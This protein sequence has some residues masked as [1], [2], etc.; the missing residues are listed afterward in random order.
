VL[1]GHTLALV[2]E[3]LAR[4]GHSRLLERLRTEP[5]FR[6]TT[7]IMREINVGR[8][9]FQI[10]RDEVKQAWA[11]A[12]STSTTAPAAKS[13][14]TRS[15]I[16]TAAATASPARDEKKEAIPNPNDTNALSPASTAQSVQIVS[17]L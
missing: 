1:W 15:V 11:W 16:K 4:L 6:Y 5:R 17:K 7:Q 3:F 2:A 12:T 13:N 14:T 10:K 9:A 8:L